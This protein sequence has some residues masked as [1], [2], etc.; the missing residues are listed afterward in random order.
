MVSW[1][2]VPFYINSLSI[3]N[4]A[5]FS[6]LLLAPRNVFYKTSLHKN[7]SRF[8][9]FLKDSWVDAHPRTAVELLKPNYKC[10]GGGAKKSPIVVSI[11][12]ENIFA[13]GYV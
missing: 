10:I 4:I 12:G 2:L 9:Q 6:K 11:L 7:S 8:F 5:L 13:I 1:S 3:Q